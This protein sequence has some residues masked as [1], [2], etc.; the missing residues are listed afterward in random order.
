L[1]VNRP[2]DLPW[3]YRRLGYALV[4]GPG[5]HPLHLLLLPAFVALIAPAHWLYATVFIAFFVSALIL[6]WAN[7]SSRWQELSTYIERW[8]LRGTPRFI[9]FFVILLALLRLAQFDYISTIL[10]S[11]PFGTV[12]GLV[13][14][15][16]TL[17]WLVEYWMSR[18]VALQLLDVL[19]PTTD[20]VRIDYAPTF[21]QP[22]QQDPVRVRRHGRYLVSHG[23]GRFAIVGTVGELNAAAG[24]PANQHEPVRAFQT[25]NLMELFSRLGESSNYP[26]DHEYVRDITRCTGIYFFWSNLLVFGVMLC[27]VIFFA[28]EHYWAYNQIDPVVTAG[29]APPAERLVDLS[30]LLQQRT[31]PMRPAI[32]VVGSGGGTRAALYTASVLNGLHRL[33]VDRDIVMVSGVSGGGVALAYF[34]ANRDALTPPSSPGQ[35]GR[36]PVKKDAERSVEDEWDCFTKG[37]ISPFIEDVLDGATEWR[38]FETTALSVL[39]AES[40]E[41]HLFARQPT[42]GSIQQLALILN[43]TVVGHPAEESD[44]LMRTIDGPKSCDE[45]EQPFNLMHGGRLIFTNLRET[46]AFPQR[47]PSII[48]D[49]RFPYQIVKDT[50]VPLASAATLNANFPPV[51]PNARLRIRQNRQDGCEYRSYYVT[52]GGAEENL[53]LISALYALDSA[54]AKIPNGARVRPIH[55]VIAEASA[56]NYDYSQDRGFSVLVGGSRERLAGGLTNAIREEIQRQLEHLQVSDGQKATVQF[57]Y[58][59]LPL[60]FRARGGFGTHWMYAKEFHLNDP[61]PRTGTWLSFSSERTAV[62][63]RNDL[64]ELWVALHDPD[65]FFCEHEQFRTN[66]AEKVRH[67]I[68]GSKD[69]GAVGRDLHLDRWKKLVGDLGQY[70]QP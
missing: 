59:G 48:A 68:C 47:E 3:S 66:N 30:G 31:E 67:W 2:S 45:S 28:R 6:V 24:G 15:T 42:L 33:G 58:L 69:D 17:F 46:G 53:G 27:F 40:F 65:T 39:L 62:I 25:Y 8:F 26:Q 35:A 37:V 63:N 54:L 55:V 51:F 29:E 14:M 52:D 23:T 16:Y 13:V 38:I 19:G 44:A 56:V 50:N 20:Q 43:S 32:V 7:M 21:A 12:F 34:A 64:E 36:C 57:H 41:R 5:Y 10:D 61:R 22:N 18:A 4:Y 70:R 9:S 11:I 49:V 1:F 60:A